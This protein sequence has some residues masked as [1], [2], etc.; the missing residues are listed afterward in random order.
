LFLDLPGLYP[1]LSSTRPY[2]RALAARGLRLPAPVF[3]AGYRTAQRLAAFR[4]MRWPL[5]RWRG[6]DEAALPELRRALWAAA[7]A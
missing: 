5:W 3:R 2:R 1:T 7:G 6:G 4:Y